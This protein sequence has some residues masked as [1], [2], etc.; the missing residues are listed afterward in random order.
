MD[1]N[2]YRKAI[3]GF[4]PSPAL[5]TRIIGEAESIRPRR[6]RRPMVIL[7]VMIL[8]I[9]LS[10]STGVA[11]G[12]SPEISER[13]P[14]LSQEETE[15]NPIQHVKILDVETDI[16]HDG[17]TEM[18]EL[19]SVLHSVTDGY[20][21]FDDLDHAILNFVDF[22]KVVFA[23]MASASHSGWN[24]LFLYRMD[25]EDYLLRYNPYMM[26]GGA[27]YA[28][29]LFYIDE[30]GGEVIV[31]ENSVDFD[32]SFG[33]SVHEHS[34]FDTNAIDAF[35]AEVNAMLPYCIE[36][37]NTDWELIEDFDREG[38]LYHVPHFLETDEDFGYIY[39]PDK[40]ILENLEKYKSTMES[41]WEG[42]E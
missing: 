34:G 36:L 21:E 2:E 15:Y 39:D 6:F 41:F 9:I 26:Q 14:F 5:R 7:I 23:E 29:Q 33:S 22:N 27:H 37:L 3:D 16:N 17:R 18:L 19:H 31:K 8:I 28:Y 35:L 32:I 40:S 25:G 10:L 38:R 11:M 1:R 24:A 42:R 12:S 30:N 20:D 13:I 4:T